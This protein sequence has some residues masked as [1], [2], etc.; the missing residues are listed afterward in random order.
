MIKNDKKLNSYQLALVIICSIFGVAILQL[1]AGLAE[2]VGNEGW[3][4]LIFVGMLVLFSIFLICKAGSLY[5]DEGL[6]GA[7]KNT[8]GKILGVILIIPILTTI[9]VAT[10]SVCQIFTISIRIFLIDKTPSYAIL[11]PF[12]FL[13]MILT[14]GELKDI[15]RFFQF[16]VPIIIII[17]LAINLLTLIGA[18]FTNLLPV[19]QKSPME[20]LRGVQRS[21]FSHLGVINLLVIYPYI[22]KRDFKSSFKASGLSLIFVTVS[23]VIINALCISKLGVGET[24]WLIHPTLSLIKSAF[25]P[26]GFIER[27]EGVF[28]S[29]WVI[30]IFATI[31]MAVYCISVIISDIFDFN[32]SKHVVTIIIPLIYVFGATVVSILDVHI[33][34]RMN[35][36]TTGFYSLFI[37]PSLFLIIN[38]IKS[39][40]RGDKSG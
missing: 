5:N 20:Y 9:F 10:C 8:F 11:I 2:T 27:L 22:Q 24:K 18:D 38:K 34:N 6:V 4:V 25:I 19:F 1:P 13:I 7:S 17:V 14:R 30:V 40:K 26:G 33:I 35:D 28:M 37:F 3:L 21:T 29:L 36:L 16:M 31:C 23:Y 32:H 12:L 15:L 39:K